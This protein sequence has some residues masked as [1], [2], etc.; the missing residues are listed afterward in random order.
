MTEQRQKPSSER[1]AEKASRLFAVDALRGLIIVFMALDHANHFIAQTHSPGEY[2]GG[3]FPVFYD[4]LAFLTRFVA[5]L[6][7]PGFFFLMG[8]GMVLFANS[9]RERGWGDWRLVR[10]FSIRGLVLI[11][12]QLLI[13]NRAWEYSPGGWGVD[14]YVGVLSALGGGLI[15]GSLLLRLKPSLLLALTLVLMVG[16]EL[17]TPGPDRWGPFFSQPVNVLLVPGGQGGLWVTYPVL[18]WLELVTFGMAFGHW[19]AD[20]PRRAFGRALKL[21]VAFLLAFAVLRQVDGFGNLRPRFGDTWMDVLTVVKYPPSI[22]FTLLTTGVNL[23]LLWVFSRAGESVRPF[24]QPLVVFGQAPLLF[25]VLHLF[26]YAGLYLLLTP[27]GTS[28]LLMY[29]VWL[30][31]LLILFPVCL[32]Y[33]R[34]KRRQPAG[35][36]LRFF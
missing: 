14:W 2:F 9:R 8:A 29:P 13:V 23:I 6:C 22:T 15:L 27:E 25:Y 20:D 26:L 7:A 17:L 11:A 16:A 5:Q 1:S 34:F 4:P 28:L 24:L 36:L 35:S 32:W 19:L 31:G 3:A 18:Q 10:H 21:G 33:G 30:L 12:L